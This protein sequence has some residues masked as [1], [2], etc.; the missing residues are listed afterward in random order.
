LYE[1]IVAVKPPIP[2][3]LPPSFH[4]YLVRNQLQ[5]A[6]Y[7][8]VLELTAYQAL[9]VVHGVGRVLSGLVLRRLRE[10]GKEG[11]REGGREGKRTEI[12]SVIGGK[13]TNKETRTSE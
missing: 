9:G 10:G 13:L 12:R 4:P 6:L 7:R 1:D 2:P 8:R 11:R 3:S 5:V